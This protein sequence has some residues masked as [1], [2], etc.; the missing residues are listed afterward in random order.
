MQIDTEIQNIK[1]NQIGHIYSSE[2]KTYYNFNYRPH[3]LL[4]SR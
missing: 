2:M 4:R 3:D 1:K